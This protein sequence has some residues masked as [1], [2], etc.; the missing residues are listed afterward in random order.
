MQAN[1]QVT[2]QPCKQPQDQ[3]NTP[4]QP[5]EQTTFAANHQVRNQPTVPARACLKLNT[6]TRQPRNQP[7]A[8]SNQRHHQPANNVKQAS[9]SNGDRDIKEVLYR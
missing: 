3:A 4:N 5:I 6:G 2:S 9:L 8:R 1:N 7:T